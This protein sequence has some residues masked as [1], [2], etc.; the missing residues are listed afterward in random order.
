VNIALSIHYG[1]QCWTPVTILV[2]VTKMLNKRCFCFW[3]RHFSG[4]ELAQYIPCTMIES[5]AR[6]FIGVG[7]G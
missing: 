3:Q 5:G 2:A 1:L 4:G 6:S 7:R